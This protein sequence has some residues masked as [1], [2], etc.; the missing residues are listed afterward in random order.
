MPRE[1]VLSLRV[2]IYLIL[3]ATLLVAVAVVFMVSQT[4]F[5]RGFT[6]IE[7]TEAQDQIKRAQAA[8]TWNVME[9]NVAVKSYRS[10]D[11]ILAFLQSRDSSYIDSELPASFFTGVKANAVAILDQKRHPRL[12]PR[13]RPQQVRVH[14]A[15]L[16]P[17][18]LP[19]PAGRPRPALPRRARTSRAC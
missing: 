13:L 5:M 14:A 15:P 9:L 4:V 17:R 16:R 12:G 2:K 1:A 18:E 11:D 8:I 19:R 6:A 7:Q 3:G 10:Q